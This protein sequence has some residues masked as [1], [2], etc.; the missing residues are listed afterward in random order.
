[1]ELPDCERIAS[2]VLRALRG[3]R[4]QTAFARR[5]GLRPNT[6]YGWEAGRRWPTAA[7]ALAASAAVG[8]PPEAIVGRFLRARPA[9]LDEVELAAPEGVAALLRELRGSLPIGEVATRAG[10]SRFSVS[11]WLSGEA[12]PRLPDLLRMVEATSSRLLDFVAAWV[13]P[14]AVPSL[15]SAWARLAA[16]R[17]M[18]LEAPWT[19]A[20]LRAIELADYRALPG[21]DPAWLATRLGL[22]LPDVERWLEALLAA[23][24]IR[25]EGS[26]FVPHEVPAVVDPAAGSALK[27]HWARVGCERLEAGTEGLFSYNVFTVS[28]QDLARLREL[29]LAYF[30]ELRAVAAHS[31][32]AER[33]VVANVQLFALDERGRS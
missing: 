24:R 28:E 13:D 11:R 25:L 27:A 4:S 19:T 33:V 9:W 14:G 8:V 26:H 3:A 10:R 20:V 16:H 5:V 17:R 22:P 29:H 6:I 7:R 30:R 12:E 23:G 2:E 31:G 21:H 15:A 18:L 1:M 32:P